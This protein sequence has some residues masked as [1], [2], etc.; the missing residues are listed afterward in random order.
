MSE[1]GSIMKEDSPL[2]NSVSWLSIEP[3]GKEGGEAEEEEDQDITY[4]FE[5]LPYK[6]DNFRLKKE[7][8]LER[9]PKL[10]ESCYARDFNLGEEAD[11][12]EYQKLLSKYDGTAVFQLVV[13]DRVWDEKNSCRMVFCRWI[14]RW[15]TTPP[16]VEKELKEKAKQAK[17]KARRKAKKAKEETDA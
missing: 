3:D 2:T 16:A 17:R 5:G 4:E 14:E 13:E 8:G 6:G 12:K 10:V 15:Y 11:L 1:D 7:D 9:Y